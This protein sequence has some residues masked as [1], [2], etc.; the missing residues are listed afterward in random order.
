MLLSI[1]TTVP[2][3]VML[4][5]ANASPVHFVKVFADNVP[6]PETVTVCAVLPLNVNAVIPVPCD[7]E[8]AKLVAVTPVN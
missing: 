5:F 2:S 8:L 3:S 7:N 1:V 4:V 6:D